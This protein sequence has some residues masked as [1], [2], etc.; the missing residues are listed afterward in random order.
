[1]CTVSSETQTLIWFKSN[2]KSN[3]NENWRCC[4]QNNWLNISHLEILRDE[5]L[6]MLAE[7][8]PGQVAVLLDCTTD[9]AVN[10]VMAAVAPRLKVGFVRWRNLHKCS[11]TTNLYNPASWHHVQGFSPGPESPFLKTSINWV[12]AQWEKYLFLNKND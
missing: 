9:Y 2:T 1:M 12:Q 11:S 7:P 8:A 3:T 4:W 5:N 10:V 6:K